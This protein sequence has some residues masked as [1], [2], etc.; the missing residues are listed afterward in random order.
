MPKK[1]NNI[2][3]YLDKI[4]LNKKITIFQSVDKF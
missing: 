4:K 3:A 2:P 1:N